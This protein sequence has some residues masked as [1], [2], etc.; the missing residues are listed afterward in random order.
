MRKCPSCGTKNNDDA[1]RCKN[2]D[3]LDILP[4]VTREDVIK[5]CPRCGTLNNPGAF[6]CKNEDCLDI[7]PQ[8][9]SEGKF[10]INNIPAVVS[11]CDAKVSPKRL[12]Q[13]LLGCFALFVIM[14]GLIGFFSSCEQ[15]AK[16]RSQEYERE[17]EANLQRIRMSREAAGHARE[18]WGLR[19]ED[20]ER[21]IGNPP[22]FKGKRGELGLT[23]IRYPSLGITVIINDDNQII[24]VEQQ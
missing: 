23:P 22:K 4:Q 18:Y 19:Y 12:L 15:K 9:Q 16:E 14:F 24:R 8:G 10:N 3:C 2:E 1:F 11:M 20:W 17:Y 5:K 13:L 7:L 21:N 6:R